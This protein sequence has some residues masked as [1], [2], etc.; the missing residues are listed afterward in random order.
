LLLSLDGDARRQVS[1][2][3]LRRP[4]LFFGGKGGV[5]KTTLAATVALR[6]AMSGRRTLLVSTDPAHSVGDALDVR[7]GN[8]AREV[9]PNLW[10]VEIDP[11]EEADRYIAGVKDRIATVTPP[12]LAAEV[13]RQIDIA[14]V[15]PGAEEAALF[16]RFTRLMD[17]AGAVYDRVVFDTAPL[18]HTLRLLALPE[19]MQLWIRGL[20]GRRRKVNVLQR[21]WR[22]VAGAAAG[23]AHAD[24]DPMLAVLEERQ[25]RFAR[26]RETV[27]DRA[28]TAFIFVV[29]PERLPILETERAAGTLGRHGIPIGA[30]LV[31]R[32]RPREA[33]GAGAVRWPG[34]ERHHVE[35]IE[36]RFRAY[37]LVPV[38]LL[39]RDIQGVDDL[40]EL[41]R[42]LFEP[43]GA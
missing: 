20:I 3:L 33:D 38:P 42:R 5:G 43:T 32:V 24:G 25:A 36:R 15:T 27:V 22:N 37:P 41:A 14:R 35:D 31:N 9:L 8:A 12:R 19:Q 13:D 26:A 10:A 18:G 6:S 28:R 21:M 16:D 4:I 34:E 40:R 29:V 30:V 17:D 11:A 39:P 23:A 2:L 1:E 7:L